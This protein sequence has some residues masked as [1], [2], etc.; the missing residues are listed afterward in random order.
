MKY[1]LF[2]GRW[3]P[4]HSGHRWLWEQKIVEGKNV[5]VAIRDIP[6]DAN[7]PFSPEQVKNM[8]EAIYAGN[9]HVK[10]IIIPDIAS[11]NY[12]RGVG[13]EVV[14]HKPND[15]IARISATEIRNKIRCGDDSWKDLVDPCIHGQVEAVL[16]K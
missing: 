6:P 13:Y 4:P 8:I 5:L 16:K 10:V 7:Q 2:I 15:A 14:E 11:I 9:D 3:Q 12:G 1:E